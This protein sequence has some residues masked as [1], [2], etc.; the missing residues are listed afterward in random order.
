MWNDT[1]E[2]KTPGPPDLPDLNL[3]SGGIVTGYHRRINVQ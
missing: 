2:L 1:P 3:T